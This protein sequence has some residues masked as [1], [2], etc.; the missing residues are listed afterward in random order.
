MNNPVLR[1]ARLPAVAAVL[2]AAA[3]VLALTASAVEPFLAAA[4]NAATAS[5]LERVGPR[6][7]GLRMATQ[8]RADPAAAAAASTLLAD[9]AGRDPADAVVTVATG[10]LTIEGPDGEHRVRLAARTGAEELLRVTE[11]DG[12][13]LAP[14]VL[15][16][17]LGLGPGSAVVLR[18][19]DE[20]VELTVTGVYE[21]LDADDPPP[22]LAAL[23]EYTR[24][25]EAREGR[26]PD[27][28]M[29]HPDAAIE[30]AAAL[31]HSSTVEWRYPAPPIRDLPGARA[32]RRRA[33]AV[34][35]AAQDRRTEL[36]GT[37][38]SVTNTTPDVSS[39]L[40]GI[41]GEADGAVAALSG[42]VRAVGLAGQAV[43]LAVVAAAAVF[44]AKRRAREYRL[45]TIRGRG[46]LAQGVRS[47][48]EAALPLTVGAT[49]GWAA[50]LG[51]VTAFGPPGQLP[52]GTGVRA[53]AA[54]AVAL[55][56]ALV[57]V[58]VATAAAV[59][60]TVRGGRRRR[61]ASLKKAP[62]EAAVL[63][64]SGAA[65][66][67]LHAG[68]GVAASG[69]APALSPLVLAF[70]VLL[71]AGTAG[72]AA[73]GLRRGLPALRRRS[74]GAHP[75]RFLTFRRLGAAPTPAIVL[76]AA[77]SLALGLVVYAGA[78]AGSL[79]TSV[80]E[81]AAVQIGADAA[82]RADADEAPEGMAHVQ[83]ARG[84]L[85]PSGELV[86]VVLADDAFADVAFWTS[87]LADT[88]LDAL[89]AQ[90]RQGDDRL[91]IAGAGLRDLDP[92]ALDVAGV[93]VPVS[94]VEVASALPGQ[95]DV[96][97]VVVADAAAAFSIGEAQG[98]PLAV[99][100]VRSELWASGPDAAAVLESAGIAPELIREA[101][102]SAEQ[103]RLVAVTWALGAL[104]AFGVL[105]SLLGL[106]GVLLFVA[107]RQQGT[108]ISYALARR[109]GLGR[110]AHVRA[111]AAE[112][113]SLL[114]IATV[115]ATAFGMLAAS[116][117]AGQID[118]LP[119]LAPGLRTGLPVPV[120]GGLLIAL[121]VAGML[122][123]VLLQ[124]RADRSNIAEV[125][126][127]A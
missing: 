32:E 6:E 79:E 104:Q 122:G 31:R 15:A 21:A 16:D 115:L 8:G 114:G 110:T 3:A 78:L 76:T 11:G 68:G 71:L 62:W 47:A 30:L 118:P 121:G 93:R 1:L 90:L 7:A 101:S 57:V 64:L 89:L 85:Q 102:A 61:L 100:Q 36:G 33:A 75:S 70:P 22:G 43:A 108:Q 95:S 113:L 41:V 88:D 10:P 28:L 26:P 4:G 29:V 82:A 25:A 52:A 24:G 45:A 72:L 83:R 69:G 67:Q 39:G 34:V 9:A 111:L 27:L 106:A 109:M 20:S 2:A 81:K 17:D 87:G 40:A 126:R 94:L 54:A 56:P 125:L 5:E 46:P 99:G 98:R 73:R 48:S 80:V 119:D 86:D 74:V 13:T 117:V 60:G 91:M 53:F 92:V 103:P 107:S 120:V 77:A 50:A 84:R 55:V 18:R 96:R 63:A 116:L 19:G 49:V 66:L 35:T 105:A 124:R 42:P 123:A 65:L 58:A 37:L 127:S 12:G 38:R 97:P 44:A 112:L 23:A 59:S 51:L 14:D